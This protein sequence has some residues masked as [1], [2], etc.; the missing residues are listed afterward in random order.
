[1]LEQS[2]M[3]PEGVVPVYDVESMT[4]MIVSF[5]TAGMETR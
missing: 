3:F 5:V 1:M 2:R 4:D